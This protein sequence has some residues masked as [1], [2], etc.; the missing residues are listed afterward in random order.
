MVRFVNGY[1]RGAWLL[2]VFLLAVTGMSITSGYHR[3]WAHRT[4]Q[5]HWSVRLV[6]ILFGTMALQHSVLVWASQH[7]T[8][9]R[10]VDDVDRDPYSA[11]RGFWFSHIGWILRNY[12]S[13]V[14]DFT[15][16]K[17]LRAR[18][19][20]RCSSTVSTCRSRW[21]MNFGGPLAFGFAFGDPMRRVAARRECCGW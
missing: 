11:Q 6:Y 4:Y 5:A 2:F 14:N 15:N 8:H 7:R 19:D 13:G 21:A 1:S 9:H 3:L 16:A 12:P 20:G 10:H 17:D 18:S